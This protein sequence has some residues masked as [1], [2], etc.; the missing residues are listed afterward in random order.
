PFSHHATGFWWTLGSMAAIAV[1]LG[2][3]FWRKRYLAR[4]R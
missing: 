2:V 3:V 1:A 4:T